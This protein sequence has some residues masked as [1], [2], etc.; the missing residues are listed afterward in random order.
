MLGS[1]LVEL[2]Y[3]DANDLSRGVTLDPEDQS[4]YISES[5]EEVFDTGNE[6][7]LLSSIDEDDSD[8]YLP[9]NFPQFILA[10]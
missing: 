1:T 7:F 3:N 4:E 5:S 6:E 9:H 2:W 10:S 8:S